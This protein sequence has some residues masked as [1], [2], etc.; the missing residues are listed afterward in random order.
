MISIQPFW[1]KFPRQEFHLRVLPADTELAATVFAN[2]P[3]LAAEPL[4]PDL[5]TVVIQ[6][7]VPPDL[8]GDIHEAMFR[9]SRNFGGGR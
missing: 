1:E 8:D 9:H 3:V 6:G 4:P 7:P 5:V 2:F